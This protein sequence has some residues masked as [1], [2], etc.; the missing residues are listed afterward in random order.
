MGGERQLELADGLYSA[1]SAERR[2]ALGA[3]K[4]PW[5]RALRPFAAWFRYNDPKP[6]RDRQDKSL[7]SGMLRYGNEPM[8]AWGSCQGGAK[9]EWIV[10]E[11]SFVAPRRIA[12]G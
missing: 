9:P 1:L 8:S 4:G 11:I 2:V 3:G 6:D 12:R 10:E 5:R 7:H